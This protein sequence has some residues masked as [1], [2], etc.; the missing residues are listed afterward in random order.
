M[1]RIQTEALFAPGKQMNMN[2]KKAANKSNN[3]HKFNDKTF[4][5][6]AVAVYLMSDS[7]W[8]ENIFCHHDVTM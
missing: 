8:D 3:N 6:A 1:Q 4:F 7:K 5:S 2:D